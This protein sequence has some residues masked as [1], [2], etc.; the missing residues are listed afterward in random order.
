MGTAAIL[1]VRNLFWEYPHFYLCVVNRFSFEFF[2]FGVPSDIV[3]FS[4]NVLK[5]N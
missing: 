2:K 3:T 1:G 4:R 5:V